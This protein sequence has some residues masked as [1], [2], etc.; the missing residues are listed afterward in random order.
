[1]MQSPPLNKDSVA[2]T[3]DV[4]GDRWT[5]LILREAFFGVQ[6]YDQ[7]QANL[8]IAT[9][10]LAQRLKK[11][12]GAGIFRREVDPEDGR[13]RCYRLTDKGR[14]LYGVCLALLAWGDRWL[15][16]AEGPPLVLVHKPC[17]QVTRPV[18]ACSACGAALAARDV[19]YRVRPAERA[20]A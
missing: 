17:G 11:L 6:R 5:F 15:A 14:D 8:G 18:V 19:D 7:M 3:L 1:M 4:I 16:D 20:G 9:N 12:A 2:R 13:R 10:I